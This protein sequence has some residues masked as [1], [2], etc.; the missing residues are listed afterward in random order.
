MKKMSKIIILIT[1]ITLIVCLSTRVFA[2][3]PIDLTNSLNGGNTTTDGNGDEDI[4]DITPDP[5]PEPEQPDVEPEP[6]PE[7]EQQ[8][9]VELEPELEPEVQQPNSTTST[10]DDGIP[11]AGV[12]ETMLMGTAFV[13]FAIIG[14]YTFMKLSEYSNI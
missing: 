4:P 9:D 5:Q 8:P 3:N 13:V 14:I 1:T 10:Y 2:D 7:P 11:H 12:E 6:E